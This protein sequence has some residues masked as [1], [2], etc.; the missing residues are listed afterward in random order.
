VGR[1]CIARRAGALCYSPPDGKVR[2]G[3]AIHSGRRLGRYQLD[4]L[5]GSG[6]FGAVYLARHADLD[7]WRA[8]KVLHEGMADDAGIRARFLREAR[9]AARLSHP[10]IVSVLEYAIED[11]AQYL[12]MD[13]VDGFTLGS[14]MSGLEPRRRLADPAVRRALADVAAALD[15]AHAQGVAHRDL[16]PSNVL[17]RRVDG[18]ALLTDFG[19]ARS[20]F[21]ADLTRT[22]RS[23]GTFAYM[24]PEQ[25]RPGQTVTTSSDV[26]SF[27][28]ILFEV[29]CGR[30]PYGHGLAA[31]AGH[32]GGDQPVASVRDAD[33]NLPGALDDAVSRGLAREPE[34][35]FASAGAL[36]GAFL[37]ATAP[38][39][40]P[41]RPPANARR[42]RAVALRVA[43]A[44]AITGV[45]ATSGV[46][47]LH[48]AGQASPAP[49]SPPS[50]PPVAASPAA[51]A[52]A[53][54]AGRSWPRYGYD[55]TRT[56]QVVSAIQL[57]L[58]WHG[59]SVGPTGADGSF[60]S[61]TEGAVLEFQRHNGLPATGAVDQPTWERLVVALG[62]K[63][64]G[65]QVEAAQRLLRAWNARLGPPI[66]GVYGAPTE[67]ALKAFL[68]ARHLPSSDRLDADA[69]C[70]LVGGRIVGPPPA[71]SPQPAPAS[72]GQGTVAR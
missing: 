24:S 59:L 27:A 66:D 25:C 35:R 29:A 37:A 71:P 19:L 52:P 38:I 70:V 4:R 48:G 36:A 46:L 69:W 45:L 55:L 56:S 72:G 1:T 15:H 58:I 57:L 54:A 47:A 26:Y 40:S 8:I 67:A 34:E 65:P 51:P 28:A 33:P 61:D 13:Y 41:P 60:G 10:N 49:S 30:P 42:R 7:V 23:L 53:P 63:D 3:D 62:P 16:K 9:I 21:D 5:I 14:L 20:G 64:R 50:P 22:D 44:F 11:G 6:G 18:R 39:A 12:V 2:Q 68:D 43:V 31:V 32:L 17:V